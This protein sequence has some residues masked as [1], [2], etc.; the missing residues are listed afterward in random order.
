[1]KSINFKF[2]LTIIAVVSVVVFSVMR[3][4][5][6]VVNQR[7]SDINAQSK[8]IDRVL[9]GADIPDYELKMTQGEVDDL[10]DRIRRKVN[11]VAL[12][13]P[14]STRPT[15][16][17]LSKISSAF[18]D[19]V[20]SH[21]TNTRTEYVKNYVTEPSSELVDDD[22]AKADLAWLRTTVWA[23]HG[24][25]DVDSIRVQPR[26]IRGRE[27]AGSEPKGGTY[28]RDLANGKNLA[29]DGA[30]SY[31]AYE[32]FLS[33]VVPSFDGKVELELELG[34]TLINDGPR[35]G[36]SAVSCEYIGVPMGTFVYTPRP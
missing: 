22:I 11:A 25:I 31:S 1:M 27:I 17:D 14:N 20:I 15:Q 26:F 3:V 28:F 21:R 29:M 34:V 13:I 18:A 10:F 8:Q 4:W 9:V 24:N 23:R 7:K 30:G 16:T 2:A 6:Y 33:V 35:G 36:W 12:E 32:I 5:P 19:F